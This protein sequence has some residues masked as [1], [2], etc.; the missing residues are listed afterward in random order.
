MC[1]NNMTGTFG[2]IVHIT[3]KKMISSTILLDQDLPFYN[4]AL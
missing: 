4:L 1:T 2:S 3:E